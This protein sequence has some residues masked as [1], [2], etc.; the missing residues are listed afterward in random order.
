ME[1]ALF[2]Y[3]L[4][5]GYKREFLI[6]AACDARYLDRKI[7]KRNPMT[8]IQPPSLRERFRQVRTRHPKAWATGLV[9][10]CLLLGFVAGQAFDRPP[11]AQ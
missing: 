7:E 10:S 2:L 3:K 9:V 11:H 1:E 4:E 8:T 6:F 5:F